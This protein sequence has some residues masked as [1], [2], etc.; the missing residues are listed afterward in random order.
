MS[1]K[2]IF[3]ILK[4]VLSTAKFE[5]LIASSWFTDPVL[6]DIILERLRANVKV[7]IIIAENIDN[8]KLPFDKIN[9]LGG[10]CIKIKNVG[11]GM[12]HQ[13]F[14][15]VDQKIAVHG[16]YNYTLNARNNNHESVI[17]TTYKKTDKLINQIK[18]PHI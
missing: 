5:I 18:L 17:Y 16:S 10:F 12:M 13:K 8:E 2:K 7:N 11:Y 15:V 3:E 4:Q 1:I 9:D 14:C 6:F